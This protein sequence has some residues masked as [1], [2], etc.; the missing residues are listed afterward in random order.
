[1]NTAH[2]S[3]D[4]GDLDQHI[5][6]AIRG[7]GPFAISVVTVSLVVWPI[8][9]NLGA[10]GHIFYEDVFRFVVAATVGFGVSIITSPYVGTRRWL[11]N[12]ALAA[13]AVWFVL[14]TVFT[15]S[16]ADA[17]TD[18]VLGVLALIAAIVAIPTVLRMLVDMF[19]PGFNAMSKGRVLYGG[20]AIILIVAA[21]GFAVGANNDFF[22]KCSDFKVAGSDQP[23]NC[24]RD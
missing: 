1:M 16:A 15:D 14:A 24:A 6:P 19:V 3:N 21:T 2:E 12:L 18:P 17:I 20:L 13:P 22:L 9:F 7:Y 11:T 10:F 8:A 5:P 4:P 23:K